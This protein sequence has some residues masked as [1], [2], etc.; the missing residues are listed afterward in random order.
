[1]EPADLVAAAR[2]AA[3]LAGRVAG[4]DVAA[5][6]LITLRVGELT[7]ALDRVVAHWKPATGDAQLRMDEVLR[8]ATELRTRAELPADHRGAAKLEKAALLL[9]QLLEA[10]PFG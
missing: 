4:G 3:E 7:A 2:S 6:P 9:A 8:V 5:Q 1:M 10:A